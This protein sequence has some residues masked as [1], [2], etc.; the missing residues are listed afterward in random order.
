MTEK[1]VNQNQ[2]QIQRYAYGT[3]GCRFNVDVMIK[4]AH[5]IGRG[6]TL[7]SILKNIKTAT[8]KTVPEK[9]KRSAR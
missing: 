8:H 3:S 2:N 1:S 5:D 6:V 7:L 9:Q 4:I